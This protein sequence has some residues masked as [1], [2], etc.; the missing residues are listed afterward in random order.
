[1]RLVDIHNLQSDFTKQ[2]QTEEFTLARQPIKTK[3]PG[4]DGGNVT[5]HGITMSLDQHFKCTMG[6]NADN[7]SSSFIDQLIPLSCNLSRFLV[8]LN[9]LLSSNATSRPNY[10]SPAYQW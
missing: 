1:M 10:H 8:P 6:A 5:I 2:G 3:G 4:H 9:H 7:Q